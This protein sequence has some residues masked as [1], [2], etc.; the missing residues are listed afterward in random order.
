MGGQPKSEASSLSS[1]EV[2]RLWEEPTE[3]IPQNQREAAGILFLLGR[4]GCQSSARLEREGQ[5]LGPSFLLNASVSAL[6]SKP[7]ACRDIFLSHSQMNGLRIDALVQSER[8]ARQV[9]AIDNIAARVI[10]FLLAA[11]ALNQMSVLVAQAG[12]PALPKLKTETQGAFERYV[13]LAEARN[14]GELKRG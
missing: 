5:H 11:L 6:H 3:A 8:L 7:A 12:G 2:R 1:A 4:G 10:V 14:E 13:K 9:K